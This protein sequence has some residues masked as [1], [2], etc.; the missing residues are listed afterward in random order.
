MFRYL[1]FFVFVA[2][3]NAS[4]ICQKIHKD[5]QKE[6]KQTE[7]I[8][9]AS[10]YTRPKLRSSNQPFVS[11][12]YWIKNVRWAKWRKI[13]QDASVAIATQRIS[14]KY[15]VL[16]VEKRQTHT[17]ETFVYKTYHLSKKE[18]NKF[19]KTTDL[20]RFDY[21]KIYEKNDLRNFF[22]FG[23]DTFYLDGDTFDY[24]PDNIK[25]VQIKKNS[26]LELCEF[27]DRLDAKIDFVFL[28]LFGQ[29]LN[30]ISGCG[31]DLACKEFTNDANCLHNAKDY[32]E[33]LTKRRQK[34]HLIPK[35]EI[36]NSQKWLKGEFLE[37]YSLIDIWSNRFART[38]IET[39]PL[40]KLEL[41]PMFKHYYKLS[42]K[43]A[44]KYADHFIAKALS[45]SMNGFYKTDG[46]KLIDPIFITGKDVSQSSIKKTMRSY[47]DALLHQSPI[48]IGTI[49]PNLMFDFYST[50]KFSLLTDAF[51]DLDSDYLEKMQKQISSI[52]DAR[53]KLLKTLPNTDKN[54]FWL[55]SP[56]LYAAHMNH[57]SAVKTLLKYEDVNQKFYHTKNCSNVQRQGRTA[58]MYACENASS[59]VIALLIQNKAE[60]NATDSQNNNLLFY[61]N[62][63]PYIS[64]ENKQKGFGF[65]HSL[66]LRDLDIKPSFDCKKAKTSYHKAICKNASLANYERSMAK[67]YAK[68][69]ETKLAKNIR[70]TQKIWE[71]NT[72]KKCQDLDKNAQN[73]C[74]S[75]LIR[76]RSYFLQKTLEHL[77]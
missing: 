63:N 44:S 12:P 67:L 9:L 65:L 30:N 68:T 47:K 58:L 75:R 41:K 5:Y 35:D 37:Y 54:S 15:I 62:K 28:S 64:K 32:V 11:D 17:D 45:L 71:L 4:Y 42:D 29:M 39:I 43:E 60:L 74:I 53:S 26:K 33:Q 20:K 2:V 73:A 24:A 76:N 59:D 27:N 38:M 49:E 22:S 50:S 46:S 77:D 13:N 70:I 16:K 56:L 6:W 69:Q 52:N 34:I 51:F 55:K 7:K 36:L 23:T 19:L 57:F 18:L 8:S 72:Q 40:A 31:Y 3:L 1:I 14:G 10:Q 66:A 21:A 25:L 48:D 61:L